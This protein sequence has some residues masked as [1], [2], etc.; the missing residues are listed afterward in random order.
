MSADVEFSWFARVIGA[1]TLASLAVVGLLFLDESVP[2]AS[3]LSYVLFVGVALVAG[4]RVGRDATG[5]ADG[6]IARPIARGVLGWGLLFPLSF[7]LSFAVVQR[8][9]LSTVPDTS[10]ALV[11]FFSGLF[12]ASLGVVTAACFVVVLATTLAYAGVKARRG[13]GSRT[14][15]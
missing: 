12:V 8:L 4:I 1:G 5:R 7:Y 9:L 13:G 2:G 3:S 15:G 10:S 11:D 14:I 6:G